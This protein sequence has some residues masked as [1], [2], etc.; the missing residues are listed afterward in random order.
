M[1]SRT[2]DA[3]VPSNVC[4]GEAGNRTEY[5]FTSRIVSMLPGC[6]R[7]LQRGSAGPRTRFNLQDERPLPPTRQERDLGRERN[8]VLGHVEVRPCAGCCSLS[9]AAAMP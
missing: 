4:T 1:F 2:T 5:V 6:A 7:A 8:F 3:W 9:P